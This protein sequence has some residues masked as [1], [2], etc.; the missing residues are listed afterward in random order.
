VGH[1]PTRFTAT[2]S[3]G[4]YM[5]IETAVRAYRISDYERQRELR[6]E[7]LRQAQRKL[8]ASLGVLVGVALSAAAAWSVVGTV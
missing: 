2:E 3:G 4:P 6:R 8:G 5:D 7:Q 1:D